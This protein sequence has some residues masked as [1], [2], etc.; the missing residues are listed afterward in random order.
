MKGGFLSGVI[1]K[2]NDRTYASLDGAELKRYTPFSGRPIV[3]PAGRGYRFVFS[4][5]L[6]EVLGV[7]TS[8]NGEEGFRREAGRIAFS[9][10][11]GRQLGA[12]PYVPP[13]AVRAR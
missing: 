10:L 4:E 5:T 2:M 12:H 7:L 1:I 13:K 11:S 8:E 3:I 9:K 6:D